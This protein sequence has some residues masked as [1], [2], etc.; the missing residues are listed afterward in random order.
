MFKNNSKEEELCK[1]GLRKNKHVYVK[2][3]NKI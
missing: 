1:K 2:L 3:R